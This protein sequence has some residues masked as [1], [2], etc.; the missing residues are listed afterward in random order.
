MSRDAYVDAG[1]ATGVPQRSQNLDP[2]GMLAP[3]FEQINRESLMVNP[4]SH[5]PDFRCH[6]AP[7]DGIAPGAAD[8]HRVSKTGLRLADGNL[9]A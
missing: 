9:V 7:P 8:E 4:P 3:Q 1:A 5:K 6:Y 2:G